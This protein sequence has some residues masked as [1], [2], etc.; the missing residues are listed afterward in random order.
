M[1]NDS[2]VLFVKLL[3]LFFIFCCKSPRTTL[4]KIEVISIGGLIGLKFCY[5]VQTDECC[6]RELGVGGTLFSSTGFF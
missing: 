2:L 4:T 6:F 3:E 5:L 1:L